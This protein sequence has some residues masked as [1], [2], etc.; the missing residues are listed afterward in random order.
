MGLFKRNK[1][2]EESPAVVISEFSPTAISNHIAKISARAKELSGCVEI[3][4]INQLIT[5]FLASFGWNTSD[6]AHCAMEKTVRSKKRADIMLLE[7]GVCKI[8]IE[9]KRPGTKLD[10][11]INQLA[12]YFNNTHASIGILTD[13][14]QYWFFSYSEHRPGS[15]AYM[16]ESPFARVTIDKVS[17]ESKDAFLMALCKEDF[18]VQNLVNYSD[19]DYTRGKIYGLIGGAHGAAVNS[20][21]H[22]AFCI[23]NPGLSP[24]EIEQLI[25]FTNHHSRWNYR[26]DI[27]EW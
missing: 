20:F 25:N 13:G 16:N 7:H 18:N 6:P 5:P 19:A 22:K 15:G 14:I 27:S 3:T 8:V 11:H 9:A 10:P 23:V 4:C 26:H 24:L 1:H 2:A 17:L 21:V 12:G